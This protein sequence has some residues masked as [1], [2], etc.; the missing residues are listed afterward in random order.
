VVTRELAPRSA[1]SCAL[2][3]DADGD[4]DLDMALIDE[5]SDEVIVVANG[6]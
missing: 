2:L 4:G 1:S 6:G 5:E 3:F